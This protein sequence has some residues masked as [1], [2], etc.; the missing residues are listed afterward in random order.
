[1][2]YIE[3]LISDAEHLLASLTYFQSN[4]SQQFESK[5]NGDIDSRLEYQITQLQDRMK[6]LK[7]HKNRLGTSSLKPTGQPSRRCMLTCIQPDGY[8]PIHLL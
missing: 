6:K 8:I 3:D 1:M 4:N 5:D 2:G 7:L